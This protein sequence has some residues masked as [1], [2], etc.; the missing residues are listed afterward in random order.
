MGFTVCVTEKYTEAGHQARRVRAEDGGGR[1][2]D[3]NRGLENAETTHPRG[4][5]S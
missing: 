4:S 5:I 3:G 1:G 2:G